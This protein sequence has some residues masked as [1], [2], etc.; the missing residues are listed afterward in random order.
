MYITLC[1]KL[2]LFI[3]KL[4]WLLCILFSPQTKPCFMKGHLEGKTVLRGLLKQANI[5]SGE[6]SADT[7]TIRCKKKKK[8]IPFHCN[9][10]VDFHIQIL[11][12]LPP[13]QSLSPMGL[14]APC[15]RVSQ[16]L[17]V[18]TQTSKCTCCTDGLWPY[19]S[20]QKSFKAWKLLVT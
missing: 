18:Q 8:K 4:K 17:A 9:V 12:W 10:I 15:G 11:I 13:C 5:I 19:C 6:V 7:N 2:L 14:G 3:W 20:L 16:S 1:A